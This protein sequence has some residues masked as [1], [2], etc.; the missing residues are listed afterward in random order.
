MHSQRDGQWGSRMVAP[1]TE[2]WDTLAHLPFPPTLPLEP[3]PGAKASSW[4]FYSYLEHPGQR[5]WKPVP[6]SATSFPFSP[7]FATYKIGRMGTLVTV[8][9]LHNEGGPS[10]RK[11]CPSRSYPASSSGSTISQGRVSEEKLS[12]QGL[13]RGTELGVPGSSPG[14]PLQAMRSQ[15]NTP[16]FHL[17]V[18]HIQLWIK[19]IQEKKLHLCQTCT[20]LLFWSLFPKQCSITTIY[21]AFLL[22]C[23]ISHL[24]MT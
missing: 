9:E 23:V 11:G 18:F 21:T 3:A 15:A 22:C 8:Q 5:D 7:C 16:A 14:A 13:E 17:H 10:L 20:D 6:G 1:H 12:T 24:E 4:L 2:F 19:N